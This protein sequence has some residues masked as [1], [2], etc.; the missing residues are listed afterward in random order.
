M[1]KIY[2][3][4]VCLFLGIQVFAQTTIV[5]SVTD[6]DDEP[7]VGANVFVKGNPGVG[8]IADIDGN[9]TLVI[10]EGATAQSLVFSFI[11]MQTNEVEIGQR[12]TIN[13]VLKAADILFDDVVVTALGISR[14]KRSLGYASQDVNSEDIAVP[15]P[16][17]AVN[18]LQGRVA[19][20]Q[21]KSG[22][23]TV[24][25]STNV[26][27]RGI[28]SLT[29]SS[30]PLYVVDGVPISNYNI[31]GS[32]SG[33]DYGNGA[34]DINPN[35]VET[36]SVLKGAPATALYGS[37]GANGV[38][39]ITTKSGKK[40][41]G[42]GVEINS[43]T[44]FDNVYIL[45][46]FQNEYGGGYSQEFPTFDYKASGLGS[47][48]AQFDGQPVVETGADESWGPKLDGT[49]VL[50]W[51][52]FVPESENYMKMRPFEANP[53]NYKDLFDTGVTYSNSVIVSNANDVSNFRLSYTNLK[54][55]GVVPNSEMKKNT[56]SFK[57]ST[58]LASFLEAFVSFNYIKQSTT[59]RSPFGYSGS[60]TSVPG[61]MRIWTQRQIDTDLLRKY[62]YSNALGQQVG[63]NFRSIADGRTYIRWSNNPFWTLDNIY[64]EDAKDR[65]FG[66]AGFTATLLPGLTFTATGRTDYYTLNTN[67]RVGTGGTSTDYYGESRYTSYENNFEGILNYTKHFNDDWSLNAMLGGN[68][69]YSQYRSA[70]MGTVDGLVVENFFSIS[71][72]V[73]P[74]NASSYFSEKQINSVFGTAS[75]GFKDMLYL[76]VSARNDWSS[77]LAVDD[78]S[79]FYPSVSSSFVFS[80]L[81]DSSVLSY[82]KVRA[83]YAYAGKD[84]GPYKLYNVYNSS[85]Y[86]PTTTFTV[87]NTRLNP[88]LVNELT[89]E[90]EIG[91]EVSLLNNRLGGELTYFDRKT[92]DLIFDLD[93]SNTT[94]YSVA[95]I[96]AGELQ[97]TGVEAVIYGTPVKTSDFSWD[98]SLS[99]SQV[100]TKMNDLYGDLTEFEVSSAGSAWVTA[101]VG[102]DFGTMYA[103][104]GYEYYNG[105]KLV[106]ED[107]YYVQS[108]KPAEIGNMMPDY[109]GGIMNNFK[110]KGISFSALVDFQVGG[111]VYSWANRWAT[112]SGQT[113]WTVGLNDKGNP[114]RDAVT[115]GGGMRSDG[116]IPTYDGDGNV[117]S[118]RENDVYIEA[119]SY[120]NHTKR[121]PEEYMDDASYVKLRELKLGY[122]LPKQFV[123]KIGLQSATLSVVSR[124]VALLYSEARGF[125]PEQ[126]NSIS[127]SSLGYEGGSLPSSRSVGFNINLIF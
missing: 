50:H 25:G 59:G 41:K 76:D 117:V 61:G 45:P 57:G 124:N 48:W 1:K 70:Y 104:S 31:S 107:G 84:T 49:P 62:T 18:G 12:T 32:T 4:L 77:T 6:E 74:A 60:G 69:M 67:N 83:G 120:Y 10:P 87:G 22:A 82:G 66:N 114:K 95:M 43:T 116:V 14:E 112:V 38:I 99:Y 29:G 44:T 53:D 8:T 123:S 37:R 97:N 73:S 93:V 118:V 63:W 19:G 94:G 51:D 80:E 46:E 55:N 64:A 88:N 121:F 39:L 86:G 27:I 30:Q 21:I 40:K 100:D 126:V 56:I 26:I 109:N 68:I 101:T 2:G 65:V 42:L 122:D 23:G 75:V 72:T 28:N 3:I 89:S 36:M 11:G 119:S 16:T 47:E 110:Y 81:L 108:G 13:V 113:P 7:I 35:D 85:N 98:V 15:D 79:Y 92:K 103:Y 71:N 115:D 102:G 33:Y 78:Q 5:G 91:A 17:S 58:K 20:V 52:S 24:G 54:Q 90:F 34:Q 106:D 9:Y 111:L 127:N 96:N 125:D 105:R